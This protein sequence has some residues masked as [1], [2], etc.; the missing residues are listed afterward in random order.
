MTTTTTTTTAID[1]AGQFINAYLR[2]HDLNGELTSNALKTASDRA[3]K[4]RERFKKSRPKD[5]TAVDHSSLTQSQKYRRRLE[6][7]KKSAAATRVFNEVLRKECARILRDLE[8]SERKAKEE[9]SRV[10]ARL[11]YSEERL[12]RITN[13]SHNVSSKD[14]EPLNTS[15]SLS[16][17]HPYFESLQ[18][19]Q[20][21]GLHPDYTQSSSPTLARGPPESPGQPIFSFQPTVGA[22]NSRSSRLPPVP[23][24]RK[25]L[26]PH[27]Q[28]SYVKIAPAPSITTEHLTAS[29]LASLRRRR[30]NRNSDCTDESE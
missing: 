12:A 19:Y 16:S 21:H 14:A 23:T 15:H 26:S 7:N 24:I 30:T 9:L 11:A 17:T 29:V 8:M 20:S 22:D 3:E 10:R 2:E 13:K 25:M 18:S 28:N 5:D 1:H 6:N 4:A 27:S